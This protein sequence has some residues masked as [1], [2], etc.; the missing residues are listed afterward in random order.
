MARFTPAA[1]NPCAMAHAIERLF[2]TPKTTAVRPYKSSNM[3]G[4]SPEGEEKE[5]QLI[6]VGRTLLSAA[7]D[8]GVDLGLWSQ[9]QNQ[10][11]NQRTRV[12]ALHKPYSLSSPPPKPAPALLSAA[13]RRCQRRPHTRPRSRQTR[14]PG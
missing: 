2:A 8:L 11:Q 14:P 10:R 12:S 4:C 9:A 5:Y 7:F 6:C 13:S 3:Y 1:C